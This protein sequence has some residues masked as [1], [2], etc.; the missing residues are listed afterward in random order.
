MRSTPKLPLGLA[1]I[2]TYLFLSLPSTTL[3]QPAYAKVISATPIYEQV[4]TPHEECIDI[5]QQTRCQITSVQEQKIAGYHVLYVYNGQQYAQ[6]MAYDPGARVPIQAATSGESY[7]SS[8]PSNGIAVTPG[9]QTYSSV[10]PGASD[11]ES[12]QYQRND[13]DIPANIDLHLG[14]PPYV[15]KPLPILRP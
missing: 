6:R 15:G 3:A 5:A 4:T 1:A 13:A 10:A 14:R 7:S 9:Q 2:A 8:G 11:V 12:I